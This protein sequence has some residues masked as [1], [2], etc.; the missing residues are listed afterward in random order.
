MTEFEQASTI[1]LDID[2]LT[3]CPVPS[4]ETM[5][6]WASVAVSGLDQPAEL[7][8]RILDEPEAAALN[9]QW[10]G[11][12]YATNVLSFPCELPVSLPVKPL[13]DIVFCAPVI[14]REA[15]EQGKSTVAHWAHLLVHG[16]LHLS[17]YDHENEKDARVMENKEIAILAELGFPNPYET[18]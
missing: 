15:Q 8:I 7:A 17:G 1:S 9:Q 12:S 4:A 10:R 11:K 3:A 14:I 13:G 16:I 6:G 2:V 18:A 5:Q